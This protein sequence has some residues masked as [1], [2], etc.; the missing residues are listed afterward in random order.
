[1]AKSKLIANRKK[2]TIIVSKRTVEDAIG[3]ANQLASS[4]MEDNP[5]DPRLEQLEQSVAYLSGILRK[6]PQEMRA[7]GVSSIEDYF[8]D[9]KSSVAPEIKKA[10]DTIQGLTSERR[11]Q[12]SQPSPMS[13][14]DRAG[15]GYAPSSV[16]SSEETD[17]ADKQANMAG[18]AF[19]TDRNEQGEAKAPERLEVPRLA[20]K[21]K[22]E[23]EDPVA[24]APVPAPVPEA[25]APV[26]PAPAPAA[27]APE[28]TAGNAI[29]YIPTEMII[30]SI[31][32]IQKE[33]DFAQN[34]GKQDAIIEL[35]KVLKSRPVL[36]PEQPQAPKAPKQNTAPALATPAAP[37]PAGDGMTIP[38]PVQASKKADLGDHRMDSH[39][40]VNDGSGAS[41]TIGPGGS[42]AA[43]PDPI[44]PD[45]AK[46]TPDFGGLSLASLE[47][48]K[49]ADDY[50]LHDYKLSPE[51]GIAPMGQLPNADEQANRMHEEPEFEMDSSMEKE[52]VTPPG[53]SEGLM[54]KL[55]DEYPGDKSKAYA[56][57]WSIHNKKEGAEKIDAAFEAGARYAAAQIAKAANAAAGGGGW[58]T[59]YKPME[60]DEDGGRTPEIG[61]AHSKL[62]DNTG[63]NHPATVEPIKLNDQQSLKTGATKVA[64]LSTSTAVKKS[65]GYGND[66]KKMYL[67]AKTLTGVNDTRAVREAVEMIFR[68]ADAFDEATKALNKQHQQ[69]ESEA[70]AQEIKAKNKKS[71]E[72]GG[73]AL[74]AGE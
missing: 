42:S 70:E 3:R 61:E 16:M 63:I 56:T 23:A 19:V 44:S 52:A 62:E 69:E 49:T 8:D 41:A 55:K 4:W 5:N 10:I 51:E 38:P 33:E 9:A 36:Q 18:G 12:V 26:P 31:G 35:T 39:G 43:T 74:A 32:D 1:M 73:L 37:A 29:D 59:S 47:D 11:T 14:Q 54:H 25:A 57:A 30:K 27:P 24:E 34:R 7:E 20:K 2:S 45:A 64:E 60:V 21:K 6:S 15:V 17:M 72:F 67:E 48:E 65:E 53:I 68:A 66:L 13:P 28:A 50:R 40:T 22:K 46:P 71:S 58:F